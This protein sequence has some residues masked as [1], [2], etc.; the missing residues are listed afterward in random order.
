MGRKKL[1]VYK[2]CGR[3]GESGDLGTMNTVLLGG[4]LDL[5]FY[6]RGNEKIRLVLMFLPHALSPSKEM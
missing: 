2:W 6:P 1:F 4:E 3:G 5:C